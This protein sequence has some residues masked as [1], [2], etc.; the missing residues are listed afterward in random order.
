MAMP[1]TTGSLG[2]LRSRVQIVPVPN[3][4]LGV[5][6]LVAGFR[7]ERGVSVSD[8]GGWSALLGKRVVSNN[9]RK[10]AFLETTASCYGCVVG[11]AGGPPAEVD[12]DH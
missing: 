3:M 4:D 12:L 5:F 1:V 10:T 8:P 7:Q 11:P 9:S 2:W 6:R